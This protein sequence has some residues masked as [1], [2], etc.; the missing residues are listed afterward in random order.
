WLL[1][2][3]GILFRV[4][5]GRASQAPGGASPVIKATLAR[6]K[7]GKLWITSNGKIATLDRGNVVP[8]LFPDHQSNDL[9][10]RVFAA[11]DGGV[12]VIGNGRLREWREREWG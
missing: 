12:W 4:R 1:N 9:Y 3:A 8:V 10:E 7:N 11:E 2:N 6:G 5:D